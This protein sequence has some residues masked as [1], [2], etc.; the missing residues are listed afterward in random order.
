M[1]TKE[2][3]KMNAL[4]QLKKLMSKKAYKKLM[5]SHR[6]TSGFNTGTRTHKTDKHPSRARRKEMERGEEQ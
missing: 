2:T 6:A 1:H 3:D 4:K 5:K